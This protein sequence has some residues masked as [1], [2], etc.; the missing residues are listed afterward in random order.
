[1]HNEITVL[2]REWT[3]E[4]WYLHLLK[5]IAIHRTGCHGKPW[6][7]NV[8]PPLSFVHAFKYMNFCPR[9]TVF[10]PSDTPPTPHCRHY[11]ISEPLL[12]LYNIL[13]VYAIRSKQ[14]LLLQL[15]LF[16][17]INRMFM[18]FFS[19]K[20]CLCEKLQNELFLFTFVTFLI[21]TAVQLR[22]DSSRLWLPTSDLKYITKWISG[23]ML[24]FCGV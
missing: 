7:H 4:Y 24:L 6:T 23:F 9:V 12:Y 11:I 10:L 2:S 22:Y 16:P 3:S 1:M 14:V 5:A 18:L 21:S 17:Y 19:F 15:G 20:F 13:F 8:R